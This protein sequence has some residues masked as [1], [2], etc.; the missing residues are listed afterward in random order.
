MEVGLRESRGV[1]LADLGVAVARPLG[2]PV[3]PERHR[4]VGVQP[5]GAE[6]EPGVI[7]A[8]VRPGYALGEVMVREAEVVATSLEHAA[9]GEG[10]GAE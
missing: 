7:T 9:L 10:A 5:V 1:T 6:E 4:V 8:I 3:D 2:A